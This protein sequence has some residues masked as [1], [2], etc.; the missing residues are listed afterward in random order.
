MRV[1][2]LGAGRLGNNLGTIWAAAGHE[3]FYGVR[4]PA[5]DRSQAAL[6]S[7]GHGAQ[8]GSFQ[9]AATFGDVIMLAVPGANLVE[10]VSQ[11]DGL[12]GKVLIDGTNRIA[13]RQ[14]GEPASLA[15]T[16]AQLVPDARVVKAFNTLGAE[17]LKDV[18]F[19]SQN[20]SMFICGDDEEAKAFVTRLG[21]DI[22]LDVVDAGPL[23][24]A[25]LLE[26]LAWLWVVL[27]RR[28]GRDVAFKLLRR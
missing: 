21:E 1:G 6:A 19:G 27:A 4:D 16:V 11:L 23:A 12:A 13:P 22:G 3:V 14:P 8:I 7:A 26:S 24:N 15:E 17:N 28:G 18:V 20:A 2:I 9:D 10:I 5:S 25:S